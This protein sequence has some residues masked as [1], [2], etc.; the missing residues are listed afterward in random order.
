MT[1]TRTQFGLTTLAI[2]TLLFCLGAYFTFAAVQGDFGIFRRVQIEAEITTLQDE[3]TA[4]QA[5]VAELRNKTRRM[6]DSYLDLELLD[7]QARDILGLM[8][9]DEIIIR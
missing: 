9:A 8:R 6:S 1:R 7:Q 3:L 5:E 4:I 2:G